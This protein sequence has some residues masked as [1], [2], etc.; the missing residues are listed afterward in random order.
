M[1]KYSLETKLKAIN[2]V[3]ELRMSAGAVAKSLHTT[4]SIQRW[5]ALYEEHGIDGL[6]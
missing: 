3:L 6:R 5:V 1:A 4:K 2:D